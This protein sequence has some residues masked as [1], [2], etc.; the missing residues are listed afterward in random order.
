[1][2]SLAVPIA[3]VAAASVAALLPAARLRSARLRPRPL[4]VRGLV[5]LAAAIVAFL[6]ALR[7]GTTTAGLSALVVMGVLIVLFVVVELRT[8]EPA[9]DPHLFRSRPFAAAVAGIFGST[10]VLHGTFLM[11]PILVERL[12]GASATASGIVLLGIAGVSA[13]VAPYGGRLSDRVGRRRPAV[14]GSLI[15]AAGVGL[16]AVATGVIPAASVGGLLVLATLLLGVVGLG[17]GLSGSPRQAAAME[18][19]GD[20]RAGMAAGTYYTGRYLGGLVGASLGGAVLGTAV[21]AS[22]MT[23]GF[24][25]LAG[26]GVLVGAV[27]LG[28][29]GRRPSRPS[30]E[31]RIA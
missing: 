6:V 31:G 22:G 10:I 12:I 28:L 5:I 27:S 8:V 1:M 20:D 25:I 4:D 13:I 3:V 16:M 19:V 21:T 9:V 26:V 17:M 24:A 7:A 29:P 23:L 2:F 14:L 11:V 30:A 15:M 18:A